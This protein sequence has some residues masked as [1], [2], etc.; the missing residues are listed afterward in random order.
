[1]EIKLGKMAEIIASGGKHVLYGPNGGGKSSMLTMAIIKISSVS[2]YANE[3]GLK[4]LKG[5]KLNNKTCV[6]PF[7]V[8]KVRFRKPFSVR[9]PQLQDVPPFKLYYDHAYKNGMWIQ[10]SKLSYGERKY[11]A[12]SVAAK[13]L[14]EIVASDSHLIIENLESGLDPEMTK[15]LLE[16]IASFPNLHAAVEMHSPNLVET[17]VKL[18]FTVYYVKDFTARRVV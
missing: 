12:L 3:V 4:G 7:D 1:M 5:L 9:C 11:I 6:W 14:G 15:K 16:L 13:W 2:A 10:I 18:G 17:A 8:E